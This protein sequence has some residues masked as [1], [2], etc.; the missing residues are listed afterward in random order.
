MN[1]YPTNNYYLMSHFNQPNIERKN[2][3]WTKTYESLSEMCI[4]QHVEMK[5]VFT[6]QP[7][8]TTSSYDCKKCK[9]CCKVLNIPFKDQKPT[10]MLFGVDGTHCFARK[11]RRDYEKEKNHL[12]I[13]RNFSANHIQAHPNL[14]QKRRKLFHLWYNRVDNPLVDTVNQNFIYILILYTFSLH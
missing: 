12:H 6:F 2:C 14:N 3:L 11:T 1:W 7:K 5:S 4:V 13:W 9:A 10:I 8:K